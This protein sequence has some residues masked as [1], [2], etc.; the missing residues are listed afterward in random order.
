MYH[1]IVCRVVC[2]LYMSYAV[3]YSDREWRMHELTHVWCICVPYVLT[4]QMA[5]HVCARIMRMSC[6]MDASC[7]MD[8]MVCVHTYVYTCII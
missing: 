8:V 2:L 3:V 4:M 7:G 1:N 5:A 6:V